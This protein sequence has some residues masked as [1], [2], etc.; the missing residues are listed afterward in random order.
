MLSMPRF[1][2]LASGAAVAFLAIPCARAADI[3]ATIPIDRVTV[4][5]DSAIVTRAGAV[6][7]P[8]GDHRLI[9]RNLPG[10]LDPA[11]LRLSA[12][13]PNVRLG[14]IEVQHVTQDQAVNESERALNRKIRAIGDQKSAV[15]DDIAAAQ[16]Q[17]KLLESVVEKPTGAGDNAARIDGA[18]LN[19]LLG[20]VGTSDAAARARVRSAR[21]QLRDLDEQLEVLK[22]EL[23][24]VATA[25]KTTTELRATVHVA[26]DT[27][28]PLEL[29]Y[30]MA[31]AGWQWQ[32][33]ARLD[34]QEKKV[35]LMRQSEVRQGTGEDWTNVE[36]VVSTS[37]PSMNT[38]TPRIA[39]L[40]LGLRTPMLASSED[41]SEAL[42][43]V[44]VTGMRRGGSRRYT[45]VRSSAPSAPGKPPVSSAEVFA[46]DFVADYRIPGRVSV[47][48]DRE[49]RLYPIGDDD[50]N[51]ELVARV[52][53]AVAPTAYLEAKLSYQGE[54]PID[55]GKV[56][57]YR[58]D[59]FIGVAGL[60]LVLPGDEVRLPFGVDE[61]VRIAVR[62]EKEES[63]DHGI[64][65]KQQVDQR[66]RRFEVTSFHA[67]ALPIEVIDRVP[68]SRDDDIK[69][70]VL[71]GATPPTS[72]DLNG[73][74]GVYVWRL[75]GT[76]RKTETIRHYYSVK[77][78]RE[79]ELAPFESN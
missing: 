67:S 54:V 15:D 19:S 66:K 42:E 73:L 47:V 1:V 23:Q 65:N 70:E 2:V 32:Y 36:M 4:Y 9:L 52:N 8:A 51:V 41:K 21:V 35:S 75:P 49:A 43:E 68:V 24:K 62:D 3:A 55:S 45:P 39:A 59:A 26:G 27:R 28:V 6:E 18:S 72:K 34:S 33:E 46:T 79:K 77:Y 16:S 48:S 63:G 50:L 57:L 38:V 76:P 71:E 61:R 53:M 30:Q 29:E 12:R 69:V 74:Q 5:R 60:P 13:S 25:R 56:Q 64:I 17:L 44:I 20:S 7:V 22:A 14:G 40:F 78:P 10:E 11:S 31:G 37:R 58:D